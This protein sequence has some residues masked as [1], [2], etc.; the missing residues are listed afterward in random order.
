MVLTRFDNCN[1]LVTFIECQ[2]SEIDDIGC[3][4]KV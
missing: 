4:F 2:K 3:Y 1:I